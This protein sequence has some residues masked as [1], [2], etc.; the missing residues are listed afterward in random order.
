LK[1]E[2]KDQRLEDILTE[3]DPPNES[4]E[5]LE[6]GRLLDEYGIPFFYKQVTIIYYEGKN[7]VW[8][9]MFTLPQYVGMVIDYMAEHDEDAQYH[10]LRRQLQ[11]LKVSWDPQIPQV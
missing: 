11:L 1:N 7:R 8:K 3:L 5:E 6:I 2:T 4:K 10:I 9:P